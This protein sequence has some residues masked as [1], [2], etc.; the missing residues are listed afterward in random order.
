MPY[1]EFMKAKE[2][3]LKVYDDE[4]II[5]LPKSKKDKFVRQLKKQMLNDKNNFVKASKAY[6]SYIRSYIEHQLGSIFKL[7]DIS[8]A[9]TAKSF[10]LFKVPFI[11]EL[12]ERQSNVKISTDA[13]LLLLEKVEFKNKNQEK[14]IK[15]KIERD[16]H[17]SN[18]NWLIFRNSNARKKKNYQEES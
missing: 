3:V 16:K 6:V 7:D 5:N 4:E 17:R 12:K 14:M 1:V 13:E 2:V 15:E 10:F 11:K 18:F 9:D 8:L